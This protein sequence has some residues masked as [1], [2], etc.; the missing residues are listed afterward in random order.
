[1]QE[2]SFKPT[3]TVPGLSHPRELVDR[4]V[5]LPLHVSCLIPAES[6]PMESGCSIQCYLYENPLPCGSICMTRLNTDVYDL[7]NCITS[8]YRCDFV[9]S[10]SRAQYRLDCVCVCCDGYVVHLHCVCMR[11]RLFLRHFA[12]ENRPVFLKCRPWEALCEDIGRLIF[13]CNLV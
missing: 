1:M 13:S 4:G 10:C 5:D 12:H 2:I 7:K 11:M 9:C 6:P 3:V 8:A